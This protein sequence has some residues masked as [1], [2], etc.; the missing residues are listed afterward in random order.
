[1]STT[2]TITNRHGK[3]R[4]RMRVR[5]KGFNKSKTFNN[6]AQAEQWARNMESRA[7]PD[8]IGGRTVAEMIDRYC[9]EVLPQK[10]R[11]TQ[12]SQHGQLMFWKSQIGRL[13]LSQVATPDIAMGKT[14]LAPK[15]NNTINSY[16]AALSHCYTVAVKEWEWC[17][18]NPVQN[19]RR[20]PKTQ[21]RVRMLTDAERARLLFYTKLVPCPYLHTIVVVTLSTGPRKSEINNM[22]FSDY[23]HTR[24]RIV[25]D[26]TKNGERRTV[27]LFGPARELMGALYLSRRPD[28]KYFFPSPQDP[29]RPGDFRYSWEMALEKAAI[30]NFCFHDLRHSAA[31]YLALQGATLQDIK[32]ILG[33]KSIQTALKYTHLTESH[34]AGLVQKMNLSIF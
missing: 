11:N 25:L 26:Q 34:T 12:L 20:M 31:S 22:K 13:K 19:V 24:G 27:R 17:E 6:L 9:V 28:Q 5:V 8:K 29:A 3:T 14:T 23:D 4:Y 33:H 21:E 30:P 32:E 10:A 15:G 18:I 2:K 16:L 7:D 1:M